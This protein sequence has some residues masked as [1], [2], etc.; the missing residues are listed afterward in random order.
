MWAIYLVLFTFNLNIKY[1]CA[2]C[3][4]IQ[5]YEMLIKEL[6]SARDSN[7]NECT[8]NIAKKTISRRF[9]S[10]K[11]LTKRCFSCPVKPLSGESSV[12]NSKPFDTIPGPK[13]FPFIGTLW[14][15]LPVLGKEKCCFNTILISILKELL[16]RDTVWNCIDA[17]LQFRNCSLLGW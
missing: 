16:L 10:H 14:K 6:V 17:V 3:K 8:M 12:P 1:T 11:L 13:S 5:F 2:T 15:Y 4:I 7:A 9:P